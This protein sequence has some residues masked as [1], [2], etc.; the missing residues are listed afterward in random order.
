MIK[1]LQLLVIAYA[2]RFRNWYTI[3]T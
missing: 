2:I 3:L 1:M